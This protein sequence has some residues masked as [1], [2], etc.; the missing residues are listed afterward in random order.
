MDV[1]P[2][3]Q[4][5]YLATD[6]NGNVHY[7]ECFMCALHL[8]NQ[9]DQVTINTSCDWYGQNYPI[10]VQSTQYGKMVTV[11]PS[12]AMFLSGGSCVINRAAYNQ[13]AADELLI[14]GYSS[15]TLRE[16]QYALPT[17]TNVTLVKDAALTY[18]GTFS[19]SPSQTPLLLVVAVVAGVA[20]VVAAMVAFRRLKQS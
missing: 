15:N 10:V 3:A 14:N 19:P 17:S 20:I 16:Q 6:G 18:A 9:Y 13:T 11:T 8:L 5:R 2:A 12:T 7:V 1:S 4:A